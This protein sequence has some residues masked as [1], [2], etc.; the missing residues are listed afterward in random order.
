[1]AL[2]DRAGLAALVLRLS[3][4]LQNFGRSASAM[5]TLPVFVRVLPNLFSDFRVTVAGTLSHRKLW[6]LA[7]VLTAGIA[8][9]LVFDHLEISAADQA[10]AVEPGVNWFLVLGEWVCSLGARLSSSPRTYSE[11]HNSSGKL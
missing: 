10:T 2:D 11:C 4:L 5:K 7:E 6:N 9:V 8:T 3:S 1:M